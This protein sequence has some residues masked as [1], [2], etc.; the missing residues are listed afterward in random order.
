MSYRFGVELSC[1]D[2]AKIPENT[3]ADINEAMVFGL[4]L[5]NYAYMNVAG[6]IPIYE[7]GVTYQHEHRG[8]TWKDACATLKR[9]R[10]NCKEFVAWRL[11]ELWH[12][13][14]NA[15]PL[16][17]VQRLG[18]NKILFHVVLEYPDGTIEDPSSN[19]GM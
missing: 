10:G 4:A 1:I 19:L 16:S 14:I 8:E 13:G 6:V 12:Q 18:P 11:A 17:I 9:G 3:L 15:M 5:A 2:P 7:S